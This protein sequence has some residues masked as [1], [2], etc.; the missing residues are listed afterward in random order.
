MSIKIKGNHWFKRHTAPGSGKDTV[1][2]GCLTLGYSFWNYPVD[3]VILPWVTSSTSQRPKFQGALVLWPHNW[4]SYDR[5]PAPRQEL[6]SAL[7]GGVCQHLGTPG[8]GVTYPV[9]FTLLLALYPKIQKAIWCNEGTT[10]LRV[11]GWILAL[12]HP[13]T[14]LLKDV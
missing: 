2:P 1:Y 8:M 11:E 6:S 12:V 9:L 13:C 5:H 14:L 4:V 10:D 3:K 7:M